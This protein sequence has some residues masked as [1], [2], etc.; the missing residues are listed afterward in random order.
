MLIDPVAAIPPP[1]D[2]AE[3]NLEAKC[4]AIGRVAACRPDDD[5]PSFDVRVLH[6]I[7]GYDWIS[8]DDS[9]S[10]RLGPKPSD[11]RGASRHVQGTVP[12]KVHEGLLI[13]AHLEP[14]D[15]GTDLY[16]PLLGG[17]SIISLE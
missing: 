2:I 13:L 8:E 7:K 12:V 9:L 15:A 5:V 1:E 11:S 16:V 14:P 6:V 3:R 17:L 10:I 4:V